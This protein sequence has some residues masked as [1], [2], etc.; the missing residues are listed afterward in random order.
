MKPAAT[1]RDGATSRIGSTID[2]DAPGRQTG[3]LRVPHSSH[4]S[5]YGWIPVPVVCLSHGTG[6][7]MLLM[8]GNHG[9]EY[10][11]Q[12]ALTRLIRMLKPEDVCGRL[13]ILP[14]I[15]APAAAAGRRTSPIDGGNLNRAFPGDPDGSPT[16]MIAHYVDSVLL[17][18]CDYA[19][20]FHSGGSSLAY[21]PCA[22]GNIFADMPERNQRVIEILD[23]FGAPVSYVATRP[24]GAERAFGASARRRGVIAFGT[25]AGGGGTVSPAALRML[26]R[27]LHRVL[28][29]LGLAP[30]L[31]VEPSHGTRLVEVGGPDYFVYATESGLLEPLVELGDEV[32]AGQMVGLMHF[33][34]TPWREPDPMF[35]ARDGMVLCKRIPGRTERGDCVFHLGTDLPR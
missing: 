3:F 29:H 23:V 14:A 5:A 12:V 20:D 33:P 6:P 2:F 35:C 32:R 1:A 30:G 8:A 16:S 9:D 27:G 11:G 26:E 22:Q 24:M 13:I 17:P 10:E 15:N 21:V 4:E 31:A 19:A 7:T 18:M 28:K 25:E 34:Q